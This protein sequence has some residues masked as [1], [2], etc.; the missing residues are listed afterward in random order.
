[1]LI[2]A[3]ACILPAQWE[4][5]TRS[6]WSFGILYVVVGLDEVAKV[7]LEFVEEHLL[8]LPFLLNSLHLFV[9]TR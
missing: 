2:V 8:L 1:M 7:Q 5:M 9:K 3:Y 4:I 6:A